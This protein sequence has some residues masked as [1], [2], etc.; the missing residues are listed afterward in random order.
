MASAMGF[1]RWPLSILYFLLSFI[2]LAVVDSQSLQ[3][4]VLVIAQDSGQ[5]AVTEG[6]N[7][8]GIPFYVLTV[9]Q[10]G[11]TLPALS[12]GTIGNYGA[13]V[14]VSQVSYDYGGGNYSSA[15]TPA[16]WTALYNYQTQF[17]VRMVHLNVYPGPLFGASA[18]GGCCGTG[19]E[20]LV[21][22]SNAAA[23]PTAGLNM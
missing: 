1:N 5:T 10:A 22:I 2:L 11:V 19:V 8:Y 6:L 3:S 9:P 14:V 13:I 23:F 16:Q 7:G 15:L 17:G 20:Q 21:S 12:T 18:L 4:T